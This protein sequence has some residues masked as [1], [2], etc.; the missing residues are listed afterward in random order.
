MSGHPTHP[1]DAAPGWS[2]CPQCATRL[3]TRLLRP[4]EPTRLACPACDFILFLDPKVA[5]GCILEIDGR[6]VLLR[7]AIPPAVGK[8]VYPGGYVDRGETVPAA[9]A[10]EALEE[11]CLQVEPRSLLGVY[12]Y[13]GSPI[14]VVV[15]VAEVVGGTLAVG[16]EALEVRTFAPE[17][18]PWNDLAFPSTFDAL[19]DYLRRVHA[20]EP[21]ADATDPAPP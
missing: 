18:L 9:A 12:S 20:M 7:R 8:W 17:A 15:Y 1:H 13:A 5:A 19:A 14:V 4:G 21:P 10:R 2:F 11:V 16:D 3:E 6:I